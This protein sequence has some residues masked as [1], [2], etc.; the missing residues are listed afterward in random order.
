[1]ANIVETVPFNFDDLYAALQ[2]KFEEKG[3]DIAEG[4]NTSQLITSMAY[5]TS[6][7]NVNTAVNINETLLPLATRRANVLQSA[8]V[9]G[10]EPSQK[11]SY[12]YS[13]ELEMLG[14]DFYL[15]RW[16]E[17]KAGDK[18][19]Y[20]VG[21]TINN[22]YNPGDK[23]TIRIKEGTFTSY[24]SDP[25]LTTIITAKDD[26]NPSEYVDIPFTNI[27]ENGIE[28]FTRYVNSA[29]AVINSLWTKSETFSLDKDMDLYSL[30]QFLRIENIDYGT[31]RIYFRIGEV[32]KTLPIGTQVNANIL[33]TSG[34]AGVIGI[35]TSVTC[36]SL[37]NAT[38]VPDSTK[39]ITQG[40]DVE[41]IASIKN[42]AP[43]FH[44]AANRAVTKSDYVSIAG[45]H[46]SVASVSAWD[47]NDD[48]YKI[49][50]EIWFSFTPNTLERSFLSDSFKTKWQLDKPYDLT[51]WYLED[52]LI[53][54][55]DET[56]SEGVFDYVK[57]YSVQGLGFTHRHPLYFDFDVDVKISKYNLITPRETVNQELFD[58]INNYFLGI[59][60]ER[61]LESFDSEYFESSLLKR[62]A[63]AENI[64]DISGITLNVKNSITFTSKHFNKENY[65]IYDT[66]YNVKHCYIP[67][68]MPYL[69]IYNAD[70]S[71]NIE[72]L[73]KLDTVN[74][75]EFASAGGEIGAFTNMDVTVNF[76]ETPNAKDEE[77]LSFPIL[78]DGS[79]VGR[80]NIINKVYQKFI[81]IDLFTVENTY[82][83]LNR[84]NESGESGWFTIGEPNKYIGYYKPIVFQPAVRDLTIT[85]NQYIFDDSTC[86]VSQIITSIERDKNVFSR[87]ADSTS[88][89]I[90]GIICGDLRYSVG[91]SYAL[92]M[93]IF[94]K[95]TFNVTYPSNNIKFIKNV[96]PRLNTVTFS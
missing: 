25:S 65:S 12:V 15:P 33:Q 80:Y 51:N 82:T 77:T 24:S 61:V 62:I 47:A 7:L 90:D 78:V 89:Q 84:F 93:D 11:I 34:T 45:R 96:I 2:N 20:Y 57:K 28:I 21:E 4:S 9:L 22:V 16:A 36:E 66:K 85:K 37:L 60:E 6:M 49:P 64:D 46:Q 53:K 91:G 76:V 32:G 95:L 81:F 92:N 41:S 14:G 5:L 58:I 8:R 31:P 38:I 3:Y 26:G 39:L 43:L 18:T 55:S 30:K 87:L 69:S 29:G 86:D 94:D 67:L 44:N 42:N 73:P 17:F 79:Q 74:A 10:Y 54:R 83:S 70:G 59:N 56:Q 63:L 88:Y 40:A 48:Y 23:L 1:M 19:Y 52:D 75:A 27:E 13:I 71:L 72:N 35:G 50:G 68:A